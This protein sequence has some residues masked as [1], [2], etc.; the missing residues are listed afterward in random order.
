[1]R[2]RFLSINPKRDKRLFENCTWIV[3]RSVNRLLMN[4]EIVTFFRFTTILLSNFCTPILKL[5]NNQWIWKQFVY[6]ACS[7]KTLSTLFGL[8]NWCNSASISSKNHC[9]LLYYVKHTTA[10]IITFTSSSA[11]VGVTM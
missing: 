8:S 4:F 3:H 6:D 7:C 1:M 2:F 9:A 11:Y 10:S 5:K